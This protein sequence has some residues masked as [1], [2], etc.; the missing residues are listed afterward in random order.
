[1]KVC[2]ET[3][4]ENEQREMAS[5]DPNHQNVG[6]CIAMAD[7]SFNNDGD[8]EALYHQVEKVLR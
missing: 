4:I 5:D 6:K 7:Y 3:F 8:L 2:F 1:M